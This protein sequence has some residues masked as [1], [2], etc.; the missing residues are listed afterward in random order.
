MPPSRVRYAAYY[1]IW[2]T[3][4]RN[5]SP[6]VFGAASRRIDSRDTVAASAYEEYRRS[7]NGDYVANMRWTNEWTPQNSTPNVEYLFLVRK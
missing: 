2:T 1:H 4:I 7:D 6:Q 5:D 3:I